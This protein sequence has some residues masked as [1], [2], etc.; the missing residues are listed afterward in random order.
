MAICLPINAF[1]KN[2][3]LPTAG[4]FVFPIE[5]SQI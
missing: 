5:I 3:N 1:D 4:S 2:D